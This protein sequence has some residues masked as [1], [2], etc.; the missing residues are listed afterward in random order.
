MLPTRPRSIRRHA[1]FR[2]RPPPAC[3]GLVAISSGESAARANFDEVDIETLVSPAK[4]A[5]ALALEIFKSDP[6]TIVLP[7]GGRLRL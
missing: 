6:P 1:R 2:T 5:Q 4:P 3:G 7:Q